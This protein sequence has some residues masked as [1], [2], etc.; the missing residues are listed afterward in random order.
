MSSKGGRQHELWDVKPPLSRMGGS[1]H[2]EPGTLLT[3]GAPSLLYAKVA[4]AKA[5]LPM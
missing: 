1:A 4:L 5:Q 3:T 2:S